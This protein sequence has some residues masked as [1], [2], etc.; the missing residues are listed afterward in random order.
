MP[1]PECATCG[2][3][4]ANN[5]P[6]ALSFVAVETDINTIL[7]GAEERPHPRSIDAAEVSNCIYGHISRLSNTIR[8]LEK[9]IMEKLAEPLISVPERLRRDCREPLPPHYPFGER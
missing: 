9:I 1:P 6:S 5:F 2:N 8:D 7:V 4:S 3:K